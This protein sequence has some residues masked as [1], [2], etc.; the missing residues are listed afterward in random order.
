[1]LI[2]PTMKRHLIFWLLNLTLLNN[3][4]SQEISQV[5]MH[6]DILK[7]IPHGWIVR[8][9]AQGDLNKDG[10]ADIVLMIQSDVPAD[11]RKNDSFGSDSINANKRGLFI[12][13]QHQDGYKFIKEAD[14]IIPEHVTPTI[15]DTYSGINIK[16]GILETAYYYW[17]NAGSW[18]TY[19]TTYKF[20]YQN[21]DFFL[22]GIEYES[23]HRGN[24][25]EE[26][27]SINL[28]TRKLYI[29]TIEPSDKQDLVESEWK[30][31]KLE[32]LPSISEVIPSQ[33]KILN[34][35]Y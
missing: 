2:I 32:N 30:Q 3:S 26:N 23:T 8:D 24:M 6:R 25:I 1:M 16:N 17:A 12:F 27:V 29:E 14:K 15:S 22:I 10:K 31:F 11:Y 13:F 18:L 19:T 34:R 20:R 9:S 28:S 5:G 7:V 35:Y 4:V 33:Y 21:N